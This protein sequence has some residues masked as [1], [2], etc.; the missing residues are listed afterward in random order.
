MAWSQDMVPPELPATLE[1]P[2][3]VTMQQRIVEGLASVVPGIAELELQQ[4]EIKGGWIFAAGDSDIDNP[5]SELH[6]RCSVGA[7]RQG[8]YVSVNTGKLTL[9]PFFAEQAIELMLD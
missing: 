2:E 1:G 6:R 5:R 4:V 8:R 7:H 9:A 3:A